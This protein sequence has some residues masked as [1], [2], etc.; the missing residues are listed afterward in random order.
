MPSLGGLIHGI[1]FFFVTTEG[2]TAVL[3]G[4]PLS[5]LI[6]ALTARDVATGAATAVSR[7][8]LVASLTSLP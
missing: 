4:I 8:F 2:G 6:A 7:F 5:A 1:T 3:L